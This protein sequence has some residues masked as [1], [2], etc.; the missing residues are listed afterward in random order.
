ML[1]KLRF[2]R[3]KL[4]T[5][6]T[7]TQAGGKLLPELHREFAEYAQKEGKKFIVMYGQTEATARMAYLPAERSLEKYGSMGIAIPG[8]RFSLIDVDGQEIQ[9]PGSGGRAGI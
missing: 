7:M 1:K 3:M 2:F 8:G 6:R 5:L 9:E 4:P